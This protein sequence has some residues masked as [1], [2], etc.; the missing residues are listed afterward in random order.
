MEKNPKGKEYGHLVSS[1]KLWPIYIDS[2]GVFSFPPIIN[3]DRTKVTDKTKNLFVELTGTD[4]KAVLQTLNIIVS[5]LAER[6]CKIE[7]VQVSY[8]GK[9]EITPVVKEETMDVS[10]EDANKLLGISLNEKKI[11]EII[12]NREWDRLIYVAEYEKNL[13]QVKLTELI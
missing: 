13:K 9:K 3:S 6:N 1:H 10:L 5:N 4:K 2:K 12:R 8:D 11:V 7:T